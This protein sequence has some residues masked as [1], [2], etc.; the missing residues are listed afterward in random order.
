MKAFNPISP[1]QAAALV[2]AAGIS[3]PMAFLANNAVAG[4]VKGYARWMERLQ[5]TG[6]REEIRDKRISP[7]LWRRIVAEGRVADVF[8][9]TVRLDGSTE[10]GGGP[11]YTIVGIRFDD[12]SLFQLVIAHGNAPRTRQPPDNGGS[13]RLTRFAAPISREVRP[14]K[15]RQSRIPKA[16]AVDLRGTHITLKEAKT[17]L[18]CGQTK[19]YELINAGTLERVD[20]PAGKRITT[21]SVK[22]VLGI[23]EKP[24]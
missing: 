8:T 10:F 9:G 17:V 4:L 1:S 23:R 22:A 24:I 6:T 13:S 20:T 15:E 14:D 12:V 2:E 7:E 5:P 21:E 18:R 11:R 3:D 16:A 19:L